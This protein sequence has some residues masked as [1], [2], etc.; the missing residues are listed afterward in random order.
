MPCAPAGVSEGL[1]EIGRAPMKSGR[2]SLIA[3]ALV[4]TPLIAAGP[5]VEF[6]AQV[7]N[8]IT[9][10]N[11]EAAS[12]DGVVRLAGLIQSEYG[13]PVEE[14]R[15]AFEQQ[16]PWGQIVAFAYIRATNGRSFEEI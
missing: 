2:L 1:K 4:V 15:W 6:D 14:L 11:R 13:T 12:S 5:R 7:N 8:A 9:K 10:L 3:I 16:F